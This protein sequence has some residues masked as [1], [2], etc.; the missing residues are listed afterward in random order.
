MKQ[1]CM[2]LR[3]TWYVSL[4]LVAMCFSSIARAEAL[5]NTNERARALYDAA[6]KEL[7]ARGP[8]R[9]CPMFEEATTIAPE[10]WGS[11]MM[12][13]ECRKREGRLASAQRAYSSAAEVA[14]R[15]GHTARAQQASRKAADLESQLAKVGA[16][17][18]G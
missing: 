13:G 7:D 16:R 6:L 10:S 11:W 2:T 14:T 8:A 9:A 17:I 15:L 4:A 12:L 5:P 3:Q 1:G 18:V